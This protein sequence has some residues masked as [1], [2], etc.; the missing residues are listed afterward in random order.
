MLDVA[1]YLY[2]AGYHL[3]DPRDTQYDYKVTCHFLMIPTV[4][5]MKYGAERL[6]SKL[7]VD[8]HAISLLKVMKGYCQILH[9]IPSGLAISLFR[10]ELSL[11]HDA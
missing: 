1:V 7:F 8:E 2:T 9:H 6:L 3:P 11:W 5:N 10:Y 4:Q